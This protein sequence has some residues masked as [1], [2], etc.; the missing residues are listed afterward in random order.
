M[1]TTGIIRRDPIHNKKST[2][3][4]EKRPNIQREIINPTNRP[5]SNMN[6]EIGYVIVNKFIIIYYT[7]LFGPQYGHGLKSVNLDFAARTNPIGTQE[8][9]H[10]RTVIAMQLK[11]RTKIV[12]F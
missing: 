7:I 8:I 11:H 10:G 9:S 12:V 3:I 4:A 1:S 5:K 2:H 6:M